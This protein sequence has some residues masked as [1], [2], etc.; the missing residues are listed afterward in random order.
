M[1]KWLFNPFIRIA[2]TRALIMGLLMMAIT[3]VVCYYST[4]HFDGVI[5]AHTGRATRMYVYFIEPLVDWG[6]VTLLF[7]IAGKIFSRSSIRF[8]DVAGTQALA[9]WVMLFTAAIGFFVV[10]PDTAHGVDELVKSIQPSMIIIGLVEMVFAIWMIAL[11]YNAFTISCNLKG[12]KAIG[13]FIV[14]LLAAEILSS[15]VLHQLYKH[16][17]A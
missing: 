3:A 12:G 9:R 10:A 6:L 13:I 4:T 11:M 15:F 1:K 16:F 8:I 2:G 17:T 5:D 7:Y 14:T